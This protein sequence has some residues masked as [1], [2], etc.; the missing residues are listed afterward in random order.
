MQ[1]EQE[2]YKIVMEEKLKTLWKLFYLE[3]VDK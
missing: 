3:R 1:N 2:S